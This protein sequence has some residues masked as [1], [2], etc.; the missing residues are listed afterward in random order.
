MT[1]AASPKNLFFLKTWQPFVHDPVLQIASKGK[2]YA[3]TTG[4]IAPDAPNPPAGQIHSGGSQPEVRR[5]LA[6]LPDHGAI[7]SGGIP[8]KKVGLGRGFLFR[9]LLCFLK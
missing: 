5:T 4:S 2:Q 7:Q 8:C 9:S 3:V 6:W 1:A